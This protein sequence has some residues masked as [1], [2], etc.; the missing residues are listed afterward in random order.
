MV[1]AADMK[2]NSAAMSESFLISNMSSQ[3]SRQDQRLCVG[4]SAP[5]CL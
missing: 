2:W 5:G 4:R 1:P 3:C